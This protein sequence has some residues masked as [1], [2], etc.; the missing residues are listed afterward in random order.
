MAQCVAPGEIKRFAEARAGRFPAPQTT[1]GAAT[2]VAPGG[3][4]VALVGDALHAYPPDLGQAP[5]S[6]PACAP[7]RAPPADPP[8][9]RH[10][11]T[12]HFLCWPPPPLNGARDARGGGV[13]RGAAARRA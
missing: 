13:T 3:A 7:A 11:E 5:A 8:A 4:G 6:A 9:P 10:G 2:W 1:R 12:Q